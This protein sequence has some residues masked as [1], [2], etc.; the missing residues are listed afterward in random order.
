[1]VQICKHIELRASWDIYAAGSRLRAAI[2]AR[3]F[4]TGAY[5]PKA[6][7]S[8]FEKKYLEQGTMLY[9]VKTLP[10]PDQQLLG[11]LSPEVKTDGL[12]FELVAR[13]VTCLTSRLVRLLPWA[14][15]E[16]PA[17]FGRKY[18]RII[19]GRS[20]PCGR[21]N[22]EPATLLLLGLGTK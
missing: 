15:S 17:P 14:E 9:S 3:S 21:A 6:P 1:M 8:L 20:G 2:G 12:R 4:G 22:L 7:I 19:L 5:Q 10:T 11:K 18:R 13:S 16:V